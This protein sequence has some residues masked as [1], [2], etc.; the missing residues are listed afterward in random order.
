MR[1]PTHRSAIPSSLVN[2]FRLAAFCLFCT[3]LACGD[4]PADSS[5]SGTDGGTS[6]GSPTT[7]PETASTSGDTGSATGSATGSSTTEGTATE[8][9]GSSTCNAATAY[10]QLEPGPFVISLDPEG[11]YFNQ[12]SRPRPSVDGRYVLFSQLDLG[13]P[14]GLTLHLVDNECGTVEELPL[15]G[16][17]SG[18][19]R[20]ALDDLELSAD[21]STVVFNMRDPETGG[22]PAF[23][24]DV[25]TGALERLDVLPDDTPSQ[26]VADH[27]SVS[28]DGRFVTFTTDAALTPDDDGMGIFDIVVRDRVRGVTELVS[29][30]TDGSKSSNHCYAPTI[31]ADGRFVAFEAFASSLSPEYW[32]NG[33]HAYV[34][35]RQRGVLELAS[36]QPPGLPNGTS[37]GW[38]PHLSADGR[39]LAFATE[40]AHLPED[41]D[42]E[43]DIYVLNR[44]TGQVEL[45]SV[46]APAELGALANDESIITDD[47]QR[48]IYIA[49]ELDEPQVHALLL[50]RATGITIEPEPAPT[51]DLLDFEISDLRLSGDGAWLVA[52][53]TTPDIVDPPLPPATSAIVMRR[54]DPLF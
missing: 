42:E 5:A 17:D 47:G 27:L 24:L 15:E 14:V 38:R 40:Y 45:V 54:V 39:H 3:L 46:S 10:N 52:V 29:V 19:L 30:A 7:A 12:P 51:G 44:D 6:S 37:T 2:P 22:L 26:G 20:G 53:A 35:D 32:S 34:R 25:A 31:S 13:P 33:T 36:P 28:A 49:T 4:S 21:G 41:D 43:A 48:L 50:D 11:D 1:V 9:T 16:I 23:A 8:T 18:V